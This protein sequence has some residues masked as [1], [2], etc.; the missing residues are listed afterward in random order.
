LGI[1]ALATAIFLS[2][3]LYADPAGFVIATA[4]GYTP[5]DT[6][7]ALQQHLVQPIVV[8]YDPRGN[9]YYGTA[10]QVWRLNSDSTA[11]LIAGTGSSDATHPGDGGPATA[12]SLVLV[13]GLAIDASANVYI[14]D[15]GIYEI[16]KV[17]P[18]GIITKFAGTGAVPL[19]GVQSNAGSGTPA[20]NVALNP[21]SLAADSGNLYVTDVSTSS[22]LAFPF[23][24]Q[25]SRVV[26]G[27]N[28]NKT[29]GDGGLAVNASLYF[30]GSI[31]LGGGS[32]FINEA[33]G[34]RIRQVALRS[35]MISTAVTLAQTYLVD[36]GNHGL[37]ADTDGTL[38]VQQGETVARIAPGTSTPV[39]YAGGGAL[40]PGDPGAAITAT[41]V[42]PGALA[43]NPADGDLA[44]AD[45]T[46]NVVLTVTKATANIQIVAG[47]VHFAG[48]N[49]PAAMAIFSGL[50]GIAVDGSG[51]IY[52]ADVNNNRVRQISTSGIITTVA[53][54][55][56]EG[57]SGDNGPATS[58]SI[59]LKHSTPYANNI[60]VDAAGNLY[61]SDYGNARVRKVDTNGIITTVA[62]GGPS[63]IA[64]GVTATSAAILPGPVAVDINGNFYFGQATGNGVNSIPR[65]WKVDHSGRLSVFAGNGQTG[66]GGDG[67][68]AVAAQLGYVYCLATDTVGNLYLCDSVNNRVRQVSANGTIGKV[69][70]NGSG[71][72][73]AIPSGQP[74]STS[75][76]PPNAVTVDASGDIFIYTA[77]THQ[78]LEI[79]STG[80]LQPVIGAS[81]NGLPSTTSGDGGDALQATFTGVSGMA[82]DAAGDVWISDG[83]IYL[84]EALPVGSA[85]P[86]PPL[87]S[88]G[89][90]VGAGGS[91]PPVASVSSGAIASVFGS[92]FTPPGTSR[93]VQSSDMVQGKL[94]TT[95]A[96]ICVSFNGVNA[97]ITGVFPNQLNV[98]VPSVP[99][100]PLTVRVTANCGA[101]SGSISGNVAAVSANSASP[102]FF[103]Y[104]PDP[105]AGKNPVA[106]VNVTTGWPIGLAG[107]IAGVTTKP[108]TPGSIVEAY[109]TGWGATA[110]A[111]APGAIPGTAAQLA[112][113][114]T[115]T[116]G[117]SAVPAA[118]ILYAGA[119]PCCAGLY[120]VDFTVPAGTASGNLP[121]VITVNGLASPPNAYIAVG[122]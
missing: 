20:L 104:A 101:K 12:A 52:L 80:T 23:D 26:A 106:A 103:S 51:N 46:G 57:Y 58:A 84:R 4:A 75:I 120:Q 98:V 115:L 82:V 36:N 96:G 21:G 92:Y 118:D 22:V 56:V 76:G 93:Q 48:D 85:G 61:I 105:V 24:G 107:M 63:P 86:P 111:I 14:S 88:A 40:K 49:G 77:A 1:R 55:G 13:D 110:P 39:T 67:G 38:Y 7:L 34:A 43:V 87:I 10:H 15:F 113:G 64:A 79:D 16:R 2:A 27:N 78:I 30:P 29:A 102:E 91:V 19:F 97:G 62:G 73:S 70:G 72:S 60:A 83:G 18:A 114:L 94:P 117:G 9:L 121:L 116:L 45:S 37:A 33:G 44:I 119:S 42:A 122:Q 69:A 41:L 71:T 65:I 35:G 89:G 3:A 50:E 6:A 5:A 47:L 53:G 109:G 28:G 74:N 108:V 32:L 17:T 90:I 68:Q 112:S 99:P 66:N 100:G 11:T 31:A 59:N 95:L 25:T 81:S 54:N 8:A